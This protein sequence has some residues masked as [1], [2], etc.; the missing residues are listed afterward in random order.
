[1]PKSRL[2]ALKAHA[3]TV[4]VR[5]LLR[6][7]QGLAQQA[8]QNQQ[9]QGRINVLLDSLAVPAEPVTVA[10]LRTNARLAASLVSEFERQE[11]L[12][13][14]A[15]QGAE[16]LRTELHAALGQKRHAAQAA[17]RVY[18]QESEARVQR[19]YF[20]AQVIGKRP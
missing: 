8:D 14:E 9:V 20:A 17:A 3:A 11:R 6:N 1:M 16:G 13:A 12:E 2:F 19:Q 18:R 4:Q 10:H 5:S 7:I 15:R